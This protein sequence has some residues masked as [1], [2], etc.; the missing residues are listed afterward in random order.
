MDQPAQ[1]E[2]A[3]PLVTVVVLPR[4]RFSLTERSLETLIANTAMPYRLVYVVGDAPDYARDYLVAARATHGFTLIQRPGFLSANAARNI[5]VDA[6]TTR[7]VA[8]VENDVVFAPGWLEALVACAEETGADLVAP[9]CLIGEPAD[10]LVHSAG[11]T[12]R[13]FDGPHGRELDERHHITNLCLNTQSVQLSRQPTDF[14]D[15]HCML[16]RRSALLRVG[17]ADEEVVSTASHT[18]LSLAVRLSGGAGYLE[19]AAVVSSPS[20]D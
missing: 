8:F 13:F 5:G 19:P 18:D 12:V 1:E 14:S 3:A 16:F 15:S 4:E 20:F 11:G 6:A 2:A 9:L 10:G 17:P 7:Y